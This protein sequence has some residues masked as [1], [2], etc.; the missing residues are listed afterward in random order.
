LF[1]EFCTANA[2]VS[3]LA[4]SAKKAAVDAAATASTVVR[5]VAVRRFTKHHLGGW[6]RAAAG[7]R[8]WGN[9]RWERSQGLRL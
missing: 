5:M 6:S 3:A 4:G 2:A 1:Q 9:P 7:E 8:Q